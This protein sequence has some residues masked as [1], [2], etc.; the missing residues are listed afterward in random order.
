MDLDTISVN[1]SVPP[2]TPIV[3]RELGVDSYDNIAVAFSATF[4]AVQQTYILLYC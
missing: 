3:C 2:S 1:V 4:E